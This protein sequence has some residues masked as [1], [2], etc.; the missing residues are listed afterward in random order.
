[1]ALGGNGGGEPTGGGVE[2]VLNI[3]GLFLLERGWLM[4][5]CEVPMI[6]AEAGAIVSV[7]CS[8]S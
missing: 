2:F 4:V 1:M 5:L 8:L 6:F 3:G 7:L